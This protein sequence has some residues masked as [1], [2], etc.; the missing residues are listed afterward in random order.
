MRMTPIPAKRGE[1]RLGRYGTIGHR[2]SFE[3]FKFGFGLYKFPEHWSIQLFGLWITLAATNT[4]P[5]SDLDGWAFSYGH[6]ERH[7]YF[8]WGSRYKFIYL[9]WMLDHC[10]E[11][12]ML[13]DG[14]F[15]P[16]KRWTRDG[17]KPEP[18]TLFREKH[19]YRY[20][21]RSGK[22]Q[23]VQATVTVER[24]TWCWR[25][26]PFKFFRWPSHSATTIEVQFSDEV[27][28]R[29]GSWK[30]GCVGC[31]YDLKPGETPVECLRRMEHERT[32]R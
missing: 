13:S 17:E 30:G 10:R 22:V 1:W 29:S 5:K 9:P 23:E 26:W 15:I 21:L 31:G 19:P 2:F 28:E 7:L 3:R 16:Y 11:E 32:F 6:Q 18:P 24:R 25:G 27:G 14:T 20:I 12:V 4:P 8:K